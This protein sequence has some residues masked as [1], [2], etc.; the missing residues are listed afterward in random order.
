[1]VNLL[2]VGIDYYV[3]FGGCGDSFYGLCEQ[4]KVVVEFY[5]M[6][7]MVYILVGDLS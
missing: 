1:M 6:V 2:I 7:K 4:G 3:L 5:M